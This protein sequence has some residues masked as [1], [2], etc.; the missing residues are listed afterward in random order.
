MTMAVDDRASAEP[1]AMAA[2]SDWPNA[3]AAP[4]WA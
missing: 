2:P 1:M 3:R 4:R